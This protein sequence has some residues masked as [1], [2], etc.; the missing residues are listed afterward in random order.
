MIICWSCRSIR[1][2]RCIK[3]NRKTTTSRV[4]WLYLSIDMKKKHSC[5]TICAQLLFKLCKSDM[6]KW[7]VNFENRQVD[8]TP[9]RNK[10]I[11]RETEQCWNGGKIL[12]T[13]VRNGFLGRESGTCRDLKERKKK[14]MRMYKYLSLILLSIICPSI[15]LS[16][17]MDQSFYSYPTL[18]S[19]LLD[20]YFSPSPSPST[21]AT[22]VV[23]DVVVVAAAGYRTR[24]R[25]EQ[26][27][28][29]Q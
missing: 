17:C 2:W 15:R 19:S 20:F 28:T 5:S 6:M 3:Q 8:V 9:R 26:T 22:V 23:I 1:S 27:M 14:T 29:Y 13:L 18:Y 11:W 12:Q 4:C 7:Q 21:D 10:V 24:A 16:V 25:R